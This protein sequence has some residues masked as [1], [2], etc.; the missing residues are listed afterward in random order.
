MASALTRLGRVA[1]RRRRLVLAI[2]LALFGAAALGAATLSGSTDDTFSI[3]GTESQQAID[4]LQERLPEANGASGRIVFAAPPGATLT[5]ARRAAVAGAVAQLA[6]VPGVQAASDPFNDGG[7]SRDGRIALAQVDF[8]RPAD[9]LE[10]GPRAAVQAA[11]ERAE[12][13]GVEVEFGGDAVIERG[14]SGIGEVIGIPVAALVLAIT[15]GSL[16]AAGLPLLTALVSVGTGLSLIIAATGFFDLNSSVPTLALMLG[17]AV[18]IDYAVFIL[19]RHRS[20]LQ[21][22]STRRSRPRTPSAPPAAPSSSP[23]RR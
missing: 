17:L 14:E 11:A 19:S 2:W 20:Q 10:D 7:L 9:A 8:D 15:F 21:E 5:G 3:P 1:F 13:A 18:G 16:L 4:L 12:R 6:H 23:A 22:G